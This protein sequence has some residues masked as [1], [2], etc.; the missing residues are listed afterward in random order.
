MA[1][2]LDINLELF[3]VNIIRSDSTQ[4]DCMTREGYINDDNLV[5]WKF[6]HIK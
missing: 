3:L 4:K 1:A 2:A 5:D 6:K